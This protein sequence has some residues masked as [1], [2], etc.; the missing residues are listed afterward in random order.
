[1][2]DVLFNINPL[3]T[4][5]YDANTL[6]I[7][8]A[9]KSA[10]GYFDT[11]K[12]KLLELTL[13]DL[14]PK[15]E[16]KKLSSF[17]SNIKNKKEFNL[18]TSLLRKKDNALI[19]C[20]FHGHEID[21]NQKKAILLVCKDISEKRENDKIVLQ[22]EK[23][24][25]SLV[26][27]SF[28]LVGII[29][30]EGYYTYMSPSSL[31]VSGI[32]PE[33]FIGKSAFAF[34][35]PNDVEK[36]SLS[37]KKVLSSGRETIA[38][39]RAKNHKNEWRWLETVLTNH[40]DD[41]A[42]N[43]IVVNTRDITKQEE[44][45]QR[46]KLLESV[47]THTN[48]A[49][50]IT[51]AEPQE[52]P[53]PKILYV[54][55]AFTKMTGYTADEVIGKTPRILQG[56]DSNY[57]ELAKLG[58]ALRNWKSYELT[59]INYKKS[60]EP[61]WINFTVNPV[62]NEDGWY[63]HW[64]AIERDVTEKKHNEQKLLEAKQKAEK[65]EYALSQ[66]SKL[67]KIGY[68][69]HNFETNTLSYS[70]Y[71]QELYG[72]TPKD[73]TLSYEEAQSYFDKPSIE[74]INK[75][76]DELK[77][78]GTS[79]DLELR[80]IN[81][82]NQ[83]L[84]VRKVIEPV[85]NDKNQIIGKRGVFQ[86]FT[87][88]KLLQEL[89]RD[90]AKM[91]KIGS[92]SVDLTEN[93]VFWSKEVHQIHETDPNTYV[94]TLEDGI[95]FYRKDFHELVKSSIENTIKT[96]EGWDFEAVIV[97]ANKNEIWIR[98]LGNAEY[99]DGKCI[100]IYGGFQDINY[101]K[102]Y[103]NRLINLS[104]N[105]PG[106]VYQY[107]INPDGTD[108][109]NHINGRVQEIWGFTAKEL[110]EDMSLAWKQIEASG[111]IEN[112]KETINKAIET[113]SRWQCQFRYI[114][115]TTGKI[116]T[117]LG[118]GSPTFL[119]D[120][121]IIFN[122][123]ILDIS[124]PARDKVLLEQTNQAA[125]IGSWEMD[126]T[127]QDDSMYWSPMVKEIVELNS[128]EATTLTKAIDFCTEESKEKIKK[129]VDL[130]ITQGIDFDLELLL[131]TR[132]G[133]KVW[134]RAI[135]SREMINGKPIKIYGS[136]QDINEK[137]LAE[138]ELQRSLKTLE[139]YKFSLDQSAIIGITDH[140][141]I[142]TS[143]N[144]NF[145]K[146][147]GYTKDEL[148][149]KTHRIVKSDY[150]SKEFY[151]ELWKTITRG[152]VFR[153]QIK[154]KAK[155]GKH[156]WVDA[157]I[158]PFLNEKDKPKQYLAIRFDITKRKLA[159]QN[160][161]ATKKR[162]ELATTSAKMGIWDWDIVNDKLTWDDKMYQL[163]GIEKDDFGGAVSAWKNGLHPDDAEKA[164]TNLNDAVAGKRDFNIVFRVVWPDKSIHYIEG[165]AI[166]SRDKDGNALRM[167]G[168]NFDITDRKRAEEKILL[169][170]E[171][172]EKVT[173]ATDD[174]IWDWDIVNDHFYR[175]NNITEFFGES[176]LKLMSRKDFW[177]DKFHPEDIDK[178]KYSLD[179]ALNNPETNKWKQ[180]YR[181]FNDVGKMLYVIDQGV[182]IRDK[183]GK[184][185][186]MVGAMADLT[187]QKK[188]DE[189]N[190]FQASLLK[191]IGQAVVATD[192][193]EKIIYWN[194]AAEAIY[195]WKAEEALG[196]KASILTPTDTNEI[197]IKEILSTLKKGE[198]WSGEF[199]VQRKDKTKFPVRVSNAPLMDENNN[200]IGMIGISSDIT[201][202]VESKELLKQHTENLE[203][204]NEK[205]KE[206]AWTQSHVVRAP[207]AR[208]LGIINL[209]EIHKGDIEELLSLL[210]HL[211]KSSQEMDEIVSKIVKE[212][213]EIDN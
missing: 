200:L 85:Y 29:N 208:I 90:V 89:N 178:I 136:F 104:Q 191:T 152:Q 95:N 206:I 157:T 42:I 115:P 176:A 97:T 75:A 128:N 94:P 35:H 113:K 192:L 25:Q 105:L 210:D 179:K 197:K 61:F 107:Q 82:K 144:D 3:P 148:I 202:E 60:G 116:R 45:K 23:R 73:G 121:T 118:L 59:T 80:M 49:V 69:D 11:S 26:E 170:N 211:K 46:L 151:S 173:E 145:C 32:K 64:I 129:A 47:I 68:W 65:N 168:S 154:N 13:K 133:K 153:G 139:D 33:D 141:G 106:I 182:I 10:I 19:D 112:V 158:V 7:L 194:N 130:L 195:G 146:I 147:S 67:A 124:Q 132:K 51:E 209:I 119:S 98:S 135:G 207:L 17:H 24:L 74:K 203:R 198:S 18:K 114:M 86:N 78:N 134:V 72:L 171:R 79:Y 14:M 77:K 117:H 138:L 27:S 180:E 123:I 120:G 50:L 125:R 16:V 127:K 167:I 193:N 111:E 189:E 41:S 162:L 122:S 40:L 71:I 87:E 44:E 8:D 175:S 183:K 34:V 149:G 63:T 92:W 31:A 22:S 205:L 96:G 54:N 83:E 70:D 109:L 131:I 57:K 142:I 37:L 188:S 213:N 187:E 62:A 101:R 150:H 155:N 169:A 204:Y 21:F 38:P 156:Y 201:K 9:N 58:E 160:L 56:P 108:K 36:V 88:E 81:A 20:V 181:I 110:I 174:A 161:V 143:V 165:H 103:E 159:E 52:K 6:E 1:M 39:F 91:V 84:F 102:Q 28:D 2:N 177:S 212:A 163:Y 93:T 137:K 166:V 185:I 140:K 5:I 184:A 12:T 55:E 4:W 100:R 66:A 190:R 99:T 186:R 172:F 126:L 199:V 48:D 196:K 30:E 164:I 15:E 76:T 53:G 43:G